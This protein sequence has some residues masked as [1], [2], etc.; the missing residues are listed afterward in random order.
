MPRWNG[1]HHT[2]ARTYLFQLLERLEPQQSLAALGP[3]R[4]LLEPSEIGRAGRVVDWHLKHQAL[5]G[6]QGSFAAQEPEAL[7]APPGF[8][9]AVGW[10]ARFGA[11][12]S[13]WLGSLGRWLIQ[14][15]RG[16]ASSSGQGGLGDGR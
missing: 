14:T 15:C 3:V 8:A 4:N 1:V 2:A 7:L 5:E 11:R 10:L 13:A 9:E 12:D 6:C 16:R